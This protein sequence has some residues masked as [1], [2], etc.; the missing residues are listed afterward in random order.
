MSNT[1]TSNDAQIVELRRN[2]TELRARLKRLERQR[3]RGSWFMCGGAVVLLI[4]ASWSPWRRAASA[5]ATAEA[6]TDNT[7]AEAVHARR[8]VVVD[9]QGVR[10]AALQTSDGVPTL[11]LYNDKFN[12]AAEFTLFPGGTPTLRL[13]DANGTLRAEFMVL[14]NGIP[15]LH[16]ADSQG[17]ARAGLIAADSADSGFYLRGPDGDL[18]AELTQSADNVPKLVL[19][20][21]GESRAA[22]VHG[23]YHEQPAIGLLDNEATG[24][25]WLHLRPGGEPSLSLAREDG[26]SCL[27]LAVQANGAG[28]V[29]IYEGPQDSPDTSTQ[30]AKP[31]MTPGLAVFDADERPRLTLGLSANRRPMVGLFDTAGAARIQLVEHADGVAGLNLFDAERVNRAEL[32]STAD[33]RPH[34]YVFDKARQRGCFL[35]PVGLRVCDIRGAT[36]A[37]ADQVTPAIVDRLSV[38]WLGAERVGIQHRDESGTPVP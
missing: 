13:R 19:S 27:Q 12:A 26:E 18:R 35:E 17:R 7:V 30:P 22:L 16:L 6:E 10:K 11:T 29:H 31:G 38:G 24:R 15:G 1:S 33:G 37:P 36:T 23:F 25:A 8:F 20:P 2:V 4:L 28:T 21:G 32:A 9:D 34:L 3:A 14:P 5:Q